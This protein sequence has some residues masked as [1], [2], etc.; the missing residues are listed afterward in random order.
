MPSAVLLCSVRQL[1]KHLMKVKTHLN[2]GFVVLFAF[3]NPDT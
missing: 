2:S 3:G 1:L